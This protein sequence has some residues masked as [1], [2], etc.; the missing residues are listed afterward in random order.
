[1]VRQTSKQEIEMNIQNAKALI[2]T[3]KEEQGKS[4]SEFESTGFFGDDNQTNQQRKDSIIEKLILQIEWA[5]HE[6]S[7]SE[8]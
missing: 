2:K 4:L 6:Q 3:L 1:M 7:G 5:L 8:N